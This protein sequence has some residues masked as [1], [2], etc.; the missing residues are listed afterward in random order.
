MPAQR[1]SDRTASLFYVLVIVSAAIVGA[2]AGY[3]WELLRDA[4]GTLMVLLLG[5]VLIGMTI[6][7]LRTRGILGA[8]LLVQTAYWLVS[9][10]LRPL[11]L[12]SVQP[13]PRYGDPIA[14]FRLFRDGYA[15]SLGTVLLP[16]LVGLSTYLIFMIFASKHARDWVV[17]AEVS[18]LALYGLLLVGW[19]FRCLQLA[20]P[21]SSVLITASFTGSVAAGGLILLSSRSPSPRLVVFLV[22]TEFL[23]SYLSAVKAPIFSV[24]L[25]LALRR[26]VDNKKFPLKSISLLAFISAVSFVV[27]QNVKTSSGRLDDVSDIERYYP[28]LVQP[29]LP[30]VRRFDLLNAASDAS[31]AGAASWMNVSR[32]AIYALQAFVPQQLTGSDKGENIGRLW[33]A[34]VSSI[35][36]PAASGQT[37]LAQNPA[38]EG[39]VIAGWPGVIVECLLVG[40]IVILVAA[41]LHSRS[42]FLAM[43]GL[44]ATS[45][46]YIFE[47]GVLGVSAGLGKSLQVAI[48]SFLVISILAWFFSKWRLADCA[49]TSNSHGD[50][51][52]S[53]VIGGLRGKRKF[54]PF[55]HRNL[56]SNVG[57]NS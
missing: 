51:G 40:A 30:V 13:K 55:V 21:S 45:Q 24:L 15:D 35:S 47:R 49:P 56:S 6:V 39:W 14:D 16:V 23:W 33:G 7:G 12:L 54:P 4:S 44:A 38:A 22:S 43:W 27:I 52:T 20:F 11:V 48:V 36:N 10:I 37:Y 3:T 26:L 32:A 18:E 29:L 28:A 17:R 46:P 31:F 9:F 42:P 1:T 25:W 19:V 5:C 2:S 8:L 50:H 53:N 41:F 57:A 34:E